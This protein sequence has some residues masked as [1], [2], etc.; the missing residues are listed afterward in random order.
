M[1]DG[2]FFFNRNTDQEAEAPGS[3]GGLLPP[4]EK[5][6]IRLDVKTQY[7]PFR[8]VRRF[9]YDVLGALLFFTARCHG[10]LYMEVVAAPPVRLAHPPAC[11]GESG[12]LRWSGFERDAGA[13][14]GAEWLPNHIVPVMF[15]QR[16]AVGDISRGDDCA[17]STFRKGEISVPC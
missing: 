17:T 7:R 3:D 13:T 10:P 14:P 4:P 5:R 2:E 6:K 12:G 11:A 16:P 9:L 1:P 15:Q 8:R